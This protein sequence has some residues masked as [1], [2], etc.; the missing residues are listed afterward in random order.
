MDAV[1]Y[2]LK[3]ISIINPKVSPL[4]DYAFSVPILQLTMDA[5]K[6]AAVDAAAAATSAS[7]ET[8]C[9]NY[10]TERAE[11]IRSVLR[12]LETGVGNSE[13]MAEWNGSAC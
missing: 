4:G 9:L 11:I 12:I 13:I 6:R 3:F 2:Y 1:I 7:I 8:E 5:N 10:R